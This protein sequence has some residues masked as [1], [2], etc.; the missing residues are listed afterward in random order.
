MPF[1]NLFV[2]EDQ[3]MLYF[4]LYNIINYPCAITNLPP[5]INMSGLKT[6]PFYQIFPL[7]AFLLNSYQ[8]KT[9]TQTLT[10]QTT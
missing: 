6:F 5:S 10:L 1:V 2:E 3:V 8:L 9:F 4:L 7:S